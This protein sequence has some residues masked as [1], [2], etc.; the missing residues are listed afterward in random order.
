M[1]ECGRIWVS[2]LWLARLS[3]RVSDLFRV[4]GV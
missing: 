4:Q 2:G 3:G 1:L